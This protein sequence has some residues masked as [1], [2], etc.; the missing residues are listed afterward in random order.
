MV[1]QILPSQLTVSLIRGS[2]SWNLPESLQFTPGDTITITLTIT[3]PT[4][5]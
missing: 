1:Q 4:E 5:E 3:N 2:I